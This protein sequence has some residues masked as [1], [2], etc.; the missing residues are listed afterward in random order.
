MNR[1]SDIAF[2]GLA[3]TASNAGSSDRSKAECALERSSISIAVERDSMVFIV[4]G[5]DRG[6]RRGHRVR[7]GTLCCRL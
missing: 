1:Q 6:E 7:R 3:V 4:T 5:D 2:A